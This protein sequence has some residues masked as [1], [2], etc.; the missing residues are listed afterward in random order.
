M[1][2]TLQLLK[3]SFRVIQRW[4][5][6]EVRRLNSLGSHSHKST[7]GRQKS[8]LNIA[9]LSSLSGT[10]FG[11]DFWGWAVPFRDS[12]VHLSYVGRCL[13]RC[14]KH[15]CQLKAGQHLQ[16]TAVHSR[17]NKNMK[18]NNKTYA[19]MRYKVNIACWNVRTL[20]DINMSRR[21]ERRTA[22]LTRKLER[23]NIDIAALSETH[24]SEKDHL[25]E[26]GSRYYVLWVRNPKDKL[27]DGGVGFAIRSA[28]VDK[29]ERSSAVTDRIMKLRVPLSCGRFLSIFSLYPRTMPASEEVTQAF[30]RALNE[31]TSSVPNNEKLIILGDSMLLLV[32]SGGYGMLW[33]D[34]VLAELTV[35]VCG[36]WSSFLSNHWYSAIL[37]SIRRISTKQL[38]VIPDPSRDIWLISFSLANTILQTLQLFELCIVLNVIRI[39]GWFGEGSS[40]AYAGKYEWQE[41]TF[42]NALM[43]KA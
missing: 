8:Y 15:C 17:R 31:A 43:L 40:C 42:L 6:G 41:S 29:I 14:I 21:P 10:Y 19:K 25:I 38:G 9:I 23:L 3:Q 1:S 16:L 26:A 4:K 12:T 18:M 35:V 27:C 39:T 2:Q 20:L 36:Y 30:Y 13:K 5:S 28:L 37:S 34:T 22:L 11:V 24:L 7:R 33:D 32:G